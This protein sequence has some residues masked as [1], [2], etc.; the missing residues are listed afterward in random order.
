MGTIQDRA[1]AMTR[2]DTGLE[3]TR[4]GGF[5]LAD[6]L[7]ALVLGSVLLAVAGPS[8]ADLQRRTAVR[9]AADEFMATQLG[10][11][12]AAIKY[13]RLAELHLDNSTARFWIQV[14]TAGSGTPDTIGTV[15]DMAKEGIQLNSSLPLICYDASGSATNRGS[16]AASLAMI[17]FAAYGHSDT[18]WVTAA[19][20]ALR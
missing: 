2:A 10:A 11:R 15:R 12:S 3:A 1:T 13:G 18:V 6:L 17:E 16:C 7:I 14:D 20:N 4:D 8:L 5:S 9:T 19:G